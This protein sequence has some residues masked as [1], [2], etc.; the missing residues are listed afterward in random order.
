M[1][2]LTRAEALASSCALAALVAATT[3][4][5]VPAG[6]PRNPVEIAERYADSGDLEQA[7]AAL[8]KSKTTPRALY[9][10][11]KAIR[12]HVAA[13]VGST[14]GSLEDGH[15]TKTDLYTV[16]PGEGDLVASA[17]EGGCVCVLSLHGRTL[18]GSSLQGLARTLGPAG[19][20]IVLGPT[21]Q[22]LVPGCE[23]DDVSKSFLDSIPHWWDERSPRSFPLEALRQAKRRYPIDTDRVILFGYSMGGH[24]TW[25]IGMRFPDRFAGIAPCAGVL[26]ERESTPN[27]RD[28]AAR[29]LLPNARALH[30]CFIHGEKDEVEPIAGS[31]KMDAALKELG[32]AHTFEE[33]PGAPHVMTSFFVTGNVPTLVKWAQ[34][35]KR[36]PA[37]AKIDA[38]SAGDYADGAFWIRIAKRTGPGAIALKGT[39]DRK[40]N[41]L[42]VSADG[43]VA[44]LDVYL[45]ERLLDLGKKVTVEVA[46]QEAVVVEKPEPDHDAILESWRSRED[47]KLLY[48]CRVRVE[49]KASH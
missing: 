44:A 20:T 21:A 4:R 41:T 37:P 29:K 26:S 2:A 6:E 45:D 1:R 42:Q 25:N 40:A 28:E 35:R 31:R 33:V 15:G 22:K 10:A 27:G 16:T 47:P 18:D 14:K 32:I 19:R 30:P 46:G 43:P 23:P 38:V 12:P 48:G 13:P 34:G 9:K 17:R 7:K 36:D 24:G 39:A 11:L 8:E 49:L 5:E 3:A